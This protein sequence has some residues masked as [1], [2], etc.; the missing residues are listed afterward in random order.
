MALDLQTAET[1][2]ACERMVPRHQTL[3]PFQ[4]NQ[5]LEPLPRPQTL[6]PFNCHFSRILSVRPLPNPWSD[7]KGADG[8]G[9]HRFQFPLGSEAP[10]IWTQLVPMSEFVPDLFAPLPFDK[11]VP[12]APSAGSRGQIQISGVSMKRRTHN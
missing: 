10:T 12:L 3:E 11:G 9:I 8:S 7:G 2:G 6:E 5:P 1:L 4:Y